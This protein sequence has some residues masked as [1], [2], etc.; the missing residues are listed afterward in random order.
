MQVHR[1]TARTFHLALIFSF[2]F[3][4]FAVL[5]VPLAQAQIDQTQTRVNDKDMAALMRNLR[6]DAKSFR[7][8]FNSA[9]HK[10]TIRKTSQ[11][12]DAKN[13]VANFA[14]QTEALLN[15]FKKDRNGQAEFTSVMN[16]AEQID[17]TVNSLTL[18]PRVTEHWQ[19]I[20]TELHRIA[21][22][23]GIPGPSQGDDIR[24]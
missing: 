16:N 21:K 10:S 2:I 5:Q 15:R 6:D 9:I 19:K 18:G 11:E 23:Y 3:G 22:A 13:Q 12:K 1:T 8:K 4:F 14:R 7:P 20:R 17:G 24:P